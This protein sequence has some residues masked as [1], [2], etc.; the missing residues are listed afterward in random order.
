MQVRGSLIN[1]TARALYESVN[2]DT[3]VRVAQM[4]IPE[5]DIYAHSGFRESIP[6]PPMDAARQI[7][8]DMSESQCYLPFIEALIHV[9]REGIMGR[10]YPIAGLREIIKAVVQAGFVFDSKSQLFLED[11]HQRRTANWG[12]L[13]P[14]REYHLAFLRIDIVHNS[15]LVRKYDPEIVKSAYKALRD[16]VLSAVEKRWGRI[17]SWEGDGGLAAFYYGSRNTLAALA[18]KEILHELFLYNRM[19]SP[20]SEPLE[21]RIAAHSGTIRYS[22]QETELRKNEAIRKVLEI[23][24]Q[25][26]AKGSITLSNSLEASMERL[27]AQRFEGFKTPEG[28]TYFSYSVRMEDA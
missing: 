21:V 22:D 8:M 14:G 10:P 20:L 6:I 11:S 2:N 9:D 27:I 17:W 1:L 3:M 5:Y 12:R 4:V 28:Q 23:E 18:A 16:L 26:T 24:S 7:V 13:V 15:K 25:H 19:E